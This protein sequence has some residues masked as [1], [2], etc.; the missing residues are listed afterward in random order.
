MF[1]LV[2]DAVPVDRSS[3]IIFKHLLTL[4][5]DLL[6]IHSNVNFK[7]AL[8]VGA[9]Y[10]WWIRRQMTHD[11]PVPPSWRWPISILSI[12][13]NFQNSLTSSHV[14]PETKWCKPDPGY[15]KLNVDAAFFPDEGSGATAAVM[16][17]IHGNFIAAQCNFVPM[18]ADAITMEAM[19][20][21]DGLFFAN[22]L[23]LNQ[24]EAESDSLQVINFCNGQERWWDEAAALFT[25]AL[26]LVR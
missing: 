20:M 16:R 5:D 6:M 26:I 1:Q 9:W 13:S 15:T 3:S 22:S 14:M 18:A 17:D 11:E 10:L 7:Q 21:R 8:M 25:D 4:P 23:G 24:I 2:E 19:A 12:A